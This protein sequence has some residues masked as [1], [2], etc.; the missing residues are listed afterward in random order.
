MTSLEPNAY[1]WLQPAFPAFAARP[2]STMATPSLLCLFFPSFG[3][4]LP[5]NKFTLICLV[6]FSSKLVG[7][8][9]SSYNVSMSILLTYCLINPPLINHT[10]IA[11][12]PS[13]I[14]RTLNIQ[15]CSTFHEATDHHENPDG[16][17]WRRCKASAGE[18][19]WHDRSGA[20][21]LVPVACGIC[22]WKCAG[23]ELAC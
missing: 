12:S 7:P 5:D 18:Q 22:P 2:D 14:N 6:M 4:A 19:S 23:A 17:L 13:C 1:H 3:T 16:S 20:I 15:Q 11:S 8:L 10:H 9:Q 21:R